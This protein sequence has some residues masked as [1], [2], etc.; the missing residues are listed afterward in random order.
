MT[1][2]LQTLRDIGWRLWDPIG[3]NGPDG[4]PDEAI[5]EYD[6][7]L[8]EAFA[9]LQ[10]GSQIQDVVAILMDIESEHMAL[11]ELPDAEERATQTVLELRAIA[12]TP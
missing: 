1:D 9:M 8:I 4:P 6:S 3:L 5:D 7:Y 10:A 11:G 12:L 2:N